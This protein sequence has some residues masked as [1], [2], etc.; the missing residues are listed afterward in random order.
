MVA[1]PADGLNL[2]ATRNGRR[3]LFGLLY[4]CEGAPIGFV[5]WALPVLLRRG[6]VS[7]EAIGA[8]T[9]LLVLPWALKFLWAPLVDVLRGPR[10]GFRGWIA[11]GQ[12]GMLATL[13]PLLWIDLGKDLDLL[14]VLLVCHACAAATQDVAID[15]LA[16]RTPP[17]E[18]GSLNG[19]MQFGMLLARGMFGGWVVGMREHWGDEGIVVFLMLTI[20]ALMPLHLVY[21]APPEPAQDNGS[22]RWREFGTRLRRVLE[23]PSTWAVLAFAATSGVAF[24]TIGSLAGPVLVDSGFD[25][26]AVA[27]FFGVNTVV[28]LAG[29]ALLG[30]WISDRLGRQLTVAVASLVLSA[31]GVALATVMRDVLAPTP[32]AQVAIESLLT[33]V[34]CGAGVF[35]AASYA[36]FMDATDPR[37]GATQ[38]SAFMGATN[39]CESWSGRLG[40]WLATREGTPVAFLVAAVAGIV[41]LPLLGLVRLRKDARAAT[42]GGDAE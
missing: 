40:G 8:L 21:R 34:Y 36:L 33:A 10:F 42:D 12:I 25:D 3:V 35:T 39:A 19:W 24:E 37:L 32:D 6:G 22:E 38:F 18:H 16:V 30:G 41:V 5:W 20:L 27:S 1:K 17:A 15:A 4:F 2:Y 14:L 29:G 13:A 9:S 23:L 7:K 11:V 31:L 26:Q 28:G